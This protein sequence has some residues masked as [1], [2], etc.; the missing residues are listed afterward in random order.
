[1]RVFSF[2]G[3]LSRAMFNILILLLY[4][5][6]VSL[7]SLGMLKLG[8]E[9]SLVWLSI[10]GIS[11]NLFVLKEVTLFGLH[12]TSSE[13]LVIGYLLTLNLIQEFYGLKWAKKAV[14]ITFL[15]LLA[16]LLISR[17]H[18]LY[19]GSGPSYEAI[20]NPLPRL[21]IASI[22]TFLIVQ[23]LDLSFFAYLREKTQGRFLLFRTTSTLFLSQ[24]IDTILFTFL[25]LWGLVQSPFH[26]ILFSICIKGIIIL[27]QAPFIAFSKRVIHV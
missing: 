17:C 16:F 19:R 11:M 20:L 4:V 18:L 24:I 10:M 12:V 23:L 14:K 22:T 25:G 8:K 1:M 27:L 5:S 3:I 13:A 15:S 21:F 2:C 6:V 7:L 26:I 9:A